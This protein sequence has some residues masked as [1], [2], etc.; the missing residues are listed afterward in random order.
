MKGDIS[1]MLATIEAR[2]SEATRA[3]MEEIAERIE[4]RAR[5]LCPVRS[6][7]KRKSTSRPRFRR[8]TQ[9]ELSQRTAA[10]FG[11]VIGK[12]RG[13]YLIP[14]YRRHAQTLI[15][16]NIGGQ[17]GGSFFRSA[18]GKNGKELFQQ[19]GTGQSSKTKTGRN[20]TYRSAPGQK[21]FSG[22]QLKN[23]ALRSRMTSRARYAI[24][25]AFINE[26]LNEN[27]GIRSIPL[28]GTPGEALVFGGT[29]RD[30]IFA[31]VFL[32][33]A[34]IIATV[35]ATAPYAKFVEYGTYK[36]RAQPFLWPAYFEI[37][38]QMPKIIKA[39]LEAAGFKVD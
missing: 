26:R 1:S 11:P 17:Y 18:K 8:M 16:G 34:E 15:G 5:Q 6:P 38:R 23:P 39:H 19:V 4:S 25:H 22:Y 20:N 14:S 36:D 30:S 13:E 9:R 35:G 33:G 2:E 27:S 31:E 37:R 7:Y 12:G 10:G 24:S 29:L 21:S 32:E 3:A 28:R